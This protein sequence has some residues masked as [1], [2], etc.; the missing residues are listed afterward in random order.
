MGFEKSMVSPKSLCSSPSR[1]R[2]LLRRELREALPR[3][4]MAKPFPGLPKLLGA[5]APIGLKG[6]EGMPPKELRLL[7]LFLRALPAGGGKVAKGFECFLHGVSG[8]A[9]FLS[10]SSSGFRFTLEI[11]PVELKAPTHS[12]DLLGVAIALEGSLGLVGR[13]ALRGR[14]RENK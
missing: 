14:E 10:A 4:K 2:M 7:P 8:G 11:R 1:L 6:V 13:V 5:G 12:C 3:W 9:I